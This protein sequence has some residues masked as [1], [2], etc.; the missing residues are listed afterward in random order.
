MRDFLTELNISNLFEYKVGERVY[1]FST[2]AVKNITTTE[3]PCDNKIWFN[4]TWK[5]IW[6]TTWRARVYLANTKVIHKKTENWKDYVILWWI[7]W[8]PL[9]WTWWEN[10]Y[11][12]MVIW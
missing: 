5:Y 2:T 4:W 6:W 8:F 7:T 10:I 11:T 9:Y 12:E 1:W 3:V